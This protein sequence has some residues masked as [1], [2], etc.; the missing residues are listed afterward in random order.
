M[1]TINVSAYKFVKISASQLPQLKNELLHE[2]QKH[3]LKGT[4]LLSEEGIN[5]FLSNTKPE[6]EAFLDL[7]MQRPEF[8]DL[9]CKFS[10]SSDQPF[11]RML[12]R[13]KK[14]IISMGVDSIKPDE[15]T[16]PHLE[17]KQLK[18]WY[19]Q[20]K[21]MVIL[22][23]RNDYEIQL[24]TFENAVNLNIETFR[25]FPDA[26][27]QLPKEYQHKPIVTFCTGGIRCEKAAALMLKKGF[28]EVYQ[29]NG[30][31]LKYFEECGGNHYNGECF[32]FDKRVAVNHQLQETKTEQCFACRMPLTVDEQAA[33]AR[34]PHCH[35]NTQTGQKA[36]EQEAT[37]SE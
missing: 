3:G 11:T 16:A 20:G 6:L 17:A 30:G 5:L 31:I 1:N 37:Q 9:P 23:T 15:F 7:L 36:P 34:C 28:K 27:N 35:G 10:P 22:D 33:D 4:I 32:V 19:D 8:S 12:V 14:E 25:A 21:D 24:G 26:L 18:Q 13:I 2:A 29:L